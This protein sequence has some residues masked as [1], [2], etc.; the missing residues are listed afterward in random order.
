MSGLAG[1]IAED[2][3]L[4]ILRELERQAD[5]RLNDLLIRRTLDIYGI[6]RDRDWIKTQLRKLEQLGAIELSPAGE[7]LVAK[8][9]REGRDHLEERSV[10]AGISR[11]ADVD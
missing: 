11:P 6:R 4:Q 10:I 9:T 7:L 8:L 1:V 2:A 5:G 3:R